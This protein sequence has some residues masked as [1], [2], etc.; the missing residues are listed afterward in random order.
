MAILVHFI[1]TGI[2]G[3]EN[4]TGKLKIPGNLYFAT[5][6]CVVLAPE[7]SAQTTTLKMSRSTR[8]HTRQKS[9]LRLEG[10]LSPE[11]KPR[12]SPLNRVNSVYPCG[13]INRQC[14]NP[15]EC[16]YQEAFALAKRRPTIFRVMYCEF[17]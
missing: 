4:T 7:I 16:S 6:S 8:Y 10:P 17:S 15:F 9:L 5:S 2:I 3:R 12:T 13:M 14:R 1:N 11:R